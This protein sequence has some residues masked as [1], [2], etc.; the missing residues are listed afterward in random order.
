M[1][2]NIPLPSPRLIDGREDLER[3]I[4][5]LLFNYNLFDSHHKLDQFIEYYNR[6]GGDNEHL[7]KITNPH[8]YACVVFYL[9]LL[10]YNHNTHCKKV[11]DEL[12]KT[13]EEIKDKSIDIGWDGE[14]IVVYL[15]E[16]I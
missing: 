9:G 10:S 7:L 6:T 1:S 13:Y 14:Q 16:A 2:N 3:E 12:V 15:N 4:R 8:T 5:Q 11:F